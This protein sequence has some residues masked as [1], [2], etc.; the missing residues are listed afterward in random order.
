MSD[1]REEILE[2]YDLKPAGPHDYNSD[3]VNFDLAKNAMDEYFKE[4]A[5]ELLQFMVDKHVDINWHIDDDR[6]FLYK[7]K[8][9]TKEQLFEIFL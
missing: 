3:I 5:L 9:I 8:W 4:R 7:G 1:R 2:Q 6:S